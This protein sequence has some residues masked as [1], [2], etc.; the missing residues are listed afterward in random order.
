MIFRRLCPNC[1]G[2]RR[3]TLRMKSERRRTEASGSRWKRE[4]VK[5]RRK[6]TVMRRGVRKREQ[7][8]TLVADQVSKTMIRNVTLPTTPPP[9]TQRK[10]WPISNPNLLLAVQD[11]PPT[12]TIQPI[13]MKEEADLVPPV[14]LRHRRVR[15]KRKICT[16]YPLANPTTAAYAYHTYLTM[17]Y[18]SQG[19]PQPHVMVIMTLTEKTSVSFR[20][21]LNGK[22][23]CSTIPTDTHIDLIQIFVKSRQSSPALNSTGIEPDFCED[24]SI[25]IRLEFYGN[26]TQNLYIMSLHQTGDDKCIIS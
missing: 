5:T 20:E 26:R 18:L 22:L 2:K 8:R 25:V 13:G 1:V 16:G 14:L 24:S 7:W 11:A 15:K 21:V 9:P 3:K 6:M 10:A 19:E 17:R 23:H 4:R 12:I